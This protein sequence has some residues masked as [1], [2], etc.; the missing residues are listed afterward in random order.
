M[1]ANTDEF[2]DEYSAYARIRNEYIKHDKLVIAL[3]FD[4]TIFDTHNKGYT[5]DRMADL[6]RFWQE[7][8]QII[9]WTARSPAYYQ[10]VRDRLDELGL[11]KI[12]K[13]NEDPD[14]IMFNGNVRN[15]HEEEMPRKLY[16]NILLDD[17]AGLAESYSMLNRLKDEIE[18]GLIEK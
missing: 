10:E 3:D 14:V 4:N 11:N 16:Y 2:L 18:N 7:R 17:R 8:A 1:A 9:V 15:I 6:M 12:T 13:I 5:Y